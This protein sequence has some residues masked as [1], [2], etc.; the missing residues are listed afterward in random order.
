MNLKSHGVAKG[1]LI[2]RGFYGIVR[3]LGLIG[4]TAALAIALIAAVGGA[5]KLAHMPDISVHRPKTT[6]ADFRQ[7]PE[8][9]RTDTQPVANDPMLAQKLLEATAARE[10]AAR[11][12]AKA[13]FE[14]RLKPHIDAIVRNLASYAAKTNQAKPA[15]QAVGD[16]VRST[17]QQF[18]RFGQAVPM[19]YVEDLDKA[20]GDLAADA[21]SLAKL[22]NS[23]PRR[24]RW[25]AFLVWYTGHYAQQLNGDVDRIDAEKS[26]A[27]SDAAEAPMLLYGAAIAFG[28][29]VFGT[30]ILVL[31]RI[32]LN[33]RPETF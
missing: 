11:E 13:E 19:E 1:S 16:Y 14:K 2:E 25:D 4:T 12:A 7:A 6:Y 32:E 3:G 15:P 31:L 17:M 29:F 5:F 23:D 18:E 22:E 9:S 8:V 33:T 20:A 10:A 28:V 30:I 24:V 21:D 27:L 26:K